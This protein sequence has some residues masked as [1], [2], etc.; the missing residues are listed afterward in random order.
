MKVYY[1]FASRS[2]YINPHMRA[3]RLEDA[4]MRSKVT[5]LAPQSR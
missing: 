4:H 5:I 1:T 3:S 2:A